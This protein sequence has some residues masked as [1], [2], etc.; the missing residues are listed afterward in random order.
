MGGQRNVCCCAI[1]VVNLKEEDLQN[2]PLET[3]KNCC[4]EWVEQSR[5][6]CEAEALY[7]HG[8]LEVPCS[9]IQL[10]MDVRCFYIVLQQNHSISNLVSQ[11]L[12]LAHTHLECLQLASFP[13]SSLVTEKL[14]R[15]ARE[16]GS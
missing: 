2:L 10:C 4:F 1:V 6:S 3:L 15:S 13:G 12:F 8:R 5:L 16:L 7:A 9:L 11:K 14:R